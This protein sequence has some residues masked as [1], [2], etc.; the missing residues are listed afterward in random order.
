LLF[1]IAGALTAA[2]GSAQNNCIDCHLELEDETLTPPAKAF[3]EDVHAKAGLTC[4]SCHGGDPAANVED[5]D[6]SRAMDPDKGY[7]GVPER[8]AIPGMC[9]RCHSDANFMRGFDPNIAVDQV[10]Q[11]RTSVHGR[12]LAEGDAK[13][14]EC[15]SCHQ[16]HGILPVKDPRA[17]VYPTQIP[18]TCG[19]CHAKA[20]Y[21]SAYGIP[22]TQ[23]EEYRT[24]VHGKAL[25]AQ[26]D[27]G[28][29]T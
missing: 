19:S 10:A 26:G 14:A 15:A 16:A 29:P 9:G 11:Y 6:Y 5:G 3:A 25:F 4:A 27:L 12:K 2:L 8:A 1:V 13:V 20:E 21:M 24:S 7:I 23:L 28:A 18:E 17:P 22:T